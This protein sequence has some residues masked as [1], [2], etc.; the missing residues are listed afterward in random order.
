MAVPL[1]EIVRTQTDAYLA[2]VDP[3]NPP[4]PATIERELLGV[5][6]D[7][8][9]IQNVNQSKK[10]QLS[11]LKTLTHSQIADILVHLH[12][13]AL[14]MPTGGGSAD[15]D[16]LAMYS[17]DGPGEG[18]YVTSVADF[19]SLVQR[20]HYGLSTHEL[21]EVLEALRGNASRRTRCVDPDLIAVNN[22][23]FNY[24]TKQ[25][26]P[27]TPELIF[28]SKSRVDYVPGAVNP[29]ITMPDGAPWDVENWVQTLSDDPEIIQVIW[30]ILGAIIRPNVRWNKAAFF[31]SEKG[32]NG[33]GTLCELM[34]E[35]CGPGTATS[36]AL[37]E[38]GKDF[39]LEPLVHASAIIV[40]ENDVGTLVDKA[41]NLK[42]II[43][44]DVIQV[45][46]KH[47]AVISLQFQGFMV[48][49]LNEFPRVKDKS[50]SFYRRQL[51]V[52]FEKNFAGVERKYIKDDYLHRSEV[53]EYVLH[54]VLHMDYYE[55][56]TPEA[57]R[58]V[59]SQYKEYNDPV[60][61]FWSETRGMWDGWDLI[62]NDAIYEAFKAW[63]EESIPSG[64]VTGKNL[65]LKDMRILVDAD[66]DWQDRSES[67][68]TKMSSAHTMR[69]PPE[70]VMKYGALSQWRWFGAPNQPACEFRGFV[71][72][73][74][75]DM[76][77]ATRGDGKLT[78]ELLDAGIPVPEP[79]A[80][81]D[82]PAITAS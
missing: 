59:L 5:V 11:P 72:T 82:K 48:Q 8:I 40:D 17:S 44:G 49:C 62:P 51:F 24:R 71:R 19:R 58:A 34:R 26:Q 30:E 42:A 7:E 6:N 52:P 80:D 12:N 3:E 20:Y 75:V 66:A 60:R 78:A 35:L 18:T 76:L 70:I 4:S 50:E 14:I 10:G 22:G 28:L 55:L 29:T 15:Y 23:I 61:A 77:A 53:L 81:P 65:F 54:R 39:K 63:F 13:I 68:A 64:K 67:S 21:H 25:L 47:R 27:F 74:W 9:E 36:V 45:N 41:A 37:A 73:T 56:S 1:N 16:L 38:M 33:K 79:A 32:N 46:R 57:S 2:T 69:Y 31:Y 43:T